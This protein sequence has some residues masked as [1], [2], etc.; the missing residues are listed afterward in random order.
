MEKQRAR[1]TAEQEG[2]KIVDWI[3]S[4]SSFTMLW[5]MG[6]KSIWGPRVG[7]ATQVL[8]AIYAVQTKAYG[9]L[10]GVALF[11]VTHIRNMRL[12]SKK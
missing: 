6:N 3:L 7:L 8:W 2:I 11:T 5:L 10:P 4:I 1:I 12:W 9:L